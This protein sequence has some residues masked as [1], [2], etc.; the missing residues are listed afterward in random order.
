MLPMSESTIVS[1]LPNLFDYL[2]KL[3]DGVC[4]CELKE[5]VWIKK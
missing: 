2:L 3:V 1:K 4:I 5:H